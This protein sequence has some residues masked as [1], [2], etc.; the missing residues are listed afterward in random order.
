MAR[1]SLG[2]LFLDE[3]F[4]SAA[5]RAAEASLAAATSSTAALSNSHFGDL[6][7]GS[8]TTRFFI[9]GSLAPGCR[10]VKGAE[11]RVIFLLDML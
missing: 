7:A 1:A 11:W 2:A 8:K 5:A 6:I 3:A 10:T 4:F 9:E